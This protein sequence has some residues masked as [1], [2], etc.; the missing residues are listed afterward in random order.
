MGEEKIRL[1]CVHCDRDDCDFVAQLPDDWHFV[2]EIAP[3]EEACRPARKGGENALDW[4]THL[5]VCPTCWV[6]QAYQDRAS[7]PVAEQNDE[8]RRTVCRNL[9]SLKYPGQ[10][11]LTVGVAAL[12]HKLPHLLD[13]VATFASF[14]ADNDAHGEHDFGTFDD[15]EDRIFWKIDYYDA[16]MK[17]G[18]AEPENP[19][20]TVR[21]LTVMLA[22][23]Y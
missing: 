20:E 16:Q 8:F 5:G 10:L 4:Q 9:P 13:Q 15:G 3:W 21:V 17:F 18:S 1:G 2:Q 6:E 12:E 11:V 22:E 23:E 14:T 19:E 7:K